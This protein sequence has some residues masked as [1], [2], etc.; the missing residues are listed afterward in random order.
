[1]VMDQLYNDIKY[2]LRHSEQG[3]TLTHFDVKYVWGCNGKWKDVKLETCLLTYK[4]K[5]FIE[6]M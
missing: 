3:A 5:K 1:M 2:S 6:G 4:F